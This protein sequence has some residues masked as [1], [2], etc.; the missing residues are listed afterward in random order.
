MSSV[1]KLITVYIALDE[2]VVDGP[3]RVLMRV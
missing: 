2:R 3:E 1:S